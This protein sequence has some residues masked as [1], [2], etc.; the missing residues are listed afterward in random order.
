MTYETLAV[1]I[2]DGIGT[3]LPNRPE[4][5]KDQTPRATG[6]LPRALTAPLEQGAGR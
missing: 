4:K 1:D 5:P 2:E 6:R 3:V